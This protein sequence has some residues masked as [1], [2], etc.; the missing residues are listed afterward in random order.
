MLEEAAEFDL[1]H[2]RIHSFENRDHTFEHHFVSDQFLAQSNSEFSGCRQENQIGDRNSVDGGYKRHCN[3]AP[4]LIH[5]VQML[6]N[7]N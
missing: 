6:H 7:L 2:T 1:E 4:Y 3:A 5:F